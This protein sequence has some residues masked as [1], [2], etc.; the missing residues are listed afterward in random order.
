MNLCRRLKRL[1]ELARARRLAA[2]A[3]IT[4]LP[5]VEVFA[6]LPAARQVELLLAFDPPPRQ[7]PEPIPD[8]A[9]LPLAEQAAAWEAYLHRNRGEHHDHL[10]ACFSC[11]S[12]P[13][14]LKVHVGTLHRPLREHR[15]PGRS[16]P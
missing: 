4:E 1:E 6:R 13:D 2:E 14:M 15:P 8:L 11:L 3:R 12:V 9:A 5:P 10:A 16:R 7:D